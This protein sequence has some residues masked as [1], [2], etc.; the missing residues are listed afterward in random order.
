MEYTLWNILDTA[1]KIG[2]GASISGVATYKITTLNHN[3]DKIKWLREAKLKAFTDLSR[4][5]LS[6]GFEN[7]TFDDEY[8]FTAI[9]SNAILLINNKILVEKIQKFI[10][11]LVHFN[12][13]E[14]Q[15][16]SSQKNKILSTTDDGTKITQNEFEIGLWLK[17]F[18]K[19]AYN[20]VDELNNDLKNT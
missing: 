10:T 13:H 12:R 20:L 16:I 6:F 7:E 2:L 3:N 15:K 17:E 14:Y 8:R 18:Q 11:D 1:I 5:L 9:A 4:E 19:K